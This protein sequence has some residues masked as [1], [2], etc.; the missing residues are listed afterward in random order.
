MNKSDSSEIENVLDKLNRAWELAARDEDYDGAFEICTQV[1][2]DYPSIP[3]GFRRRGAIWA[4]KGDFTLAIQDMNEAIALTADKA[5]YYFFRGWWHFEIGNFAETVKDQ[6]KALEVG[7]QTDFH[8]YDES[9]YF[10]RALALLYL[11]RFEEVLSNCKNVRDDFLIY[12][13]GLG[14]LTKAEIVREAVNKLDKNNE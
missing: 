10:F 11:G 7:N 12:L 4:R 13:T 1:V 8:A 14:K 2:N 5:E 3:D 6:T 9:A